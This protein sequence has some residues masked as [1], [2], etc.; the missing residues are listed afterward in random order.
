MVPVAL[1]LFMDFFANCEWPPVT[2]FWTY[3]PQTPE[4]LYKPPSAQIPRAARE[5]LH[6]PLKLTNAQG[7]SHGPLSPSHSRK[8]DTRDPFISALT[9]HC[10][11]GTEAARKQVHHPR[12]GD[13]EQRGPSRILQRRG[14]QQNLRHPFGGT[15]GCCHLH[16]APKAGLIRGL[17]WGNL[18][19]KGMKGRSV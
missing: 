16:L 2:V 12:E 15:P 3:A 17:I 7:I 18:I 19:S 9:L 13:A 5:C 6:S 1:S 8:N 11:S 14:S 4:R 10:C